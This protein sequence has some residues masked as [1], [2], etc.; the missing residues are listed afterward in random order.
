MFETNYNKLS[1]I[2]THVSISVKSL[3]KKNLLNWEFFSIFF[4]FFA[5]LAKKSVHRIPVRGLF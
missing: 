4:D 3:T 1:F 5:M 2:I